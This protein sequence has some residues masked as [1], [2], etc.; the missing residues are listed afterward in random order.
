ML[1]A[2]TFFGYHMFAVS[3]LMTKKQILNIKPSSAYTTS[4]T[5][6]YLEVS[7]NSF[8]PEESC[9]TKMKYPFDGLYSKFENMRHGNTQTKDAVDYIQMRNNKE[10]GSS[11]IS[12]GT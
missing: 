9:W 10:L 11:T 3:T 2:H 1:T 4:I 5:I 12:P 8:F 6:P 7:K